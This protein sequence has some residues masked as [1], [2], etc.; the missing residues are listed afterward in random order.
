MQQN[1]SGTLGNG[2]RS[3]TINT[4]TGDI[5]LKALPAK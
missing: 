5:D 3:L 2:T 1:V 4:Q